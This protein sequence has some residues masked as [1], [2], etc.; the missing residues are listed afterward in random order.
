M[1]LFEVESGEIVGFFR[2]AGPEEAFIK[3]VKKV[4][5]VKEKKPPMPG[6]LLRVRAVDE[7]RKP[8][9]QW[10]YMNPLDLLKKI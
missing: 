9:G 10:L 4:Q 3:A 7:N 8:Q 2:A 1:N 5:K 6:F